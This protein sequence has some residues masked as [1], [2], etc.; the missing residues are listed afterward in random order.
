MAQDALQQRAVLEAWKRADVLYMLA[1]RLNTAI[2]TEEPTIRNVELLAGYIRA[3]AYGPPDGDRLKELRPLLVAIIEDVV[4]IEKAIAQT[5]LE[6]FGGQEVLFKD[7]S[8]VLKH[9]IKTIQ[10]F[11]S[12]FN[13]L[14][15]QVSV[16]E[17]DIKCVSRAIGPDVAWQVSAWMRLA[18]LETFLAFNQ[19]DGWRCMLEQIISDGP[20]STRDEAQATRPVEPANTGGPV[21]S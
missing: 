5:T 16:P 9:Q 19:G 6:H 12:L 14:S 15:H 10:E 20:R 3:V 18:R 11:A 7:S 21:E 17:I 1:V 8:R 2:E 13:D 4:V